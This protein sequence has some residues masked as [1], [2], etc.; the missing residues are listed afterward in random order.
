M[1]CFRQHCLEQRLSRK[2]PDGF[3]EKKVSPL[4]SIFHG[5]RCDRNSLAPGKAGGSFGRL[6]PGVKPYRV[7]RPCDFSDNGFLFF[8]AIPNNNRQT[9]RCAK[10]LDLSMTNSRLT[11]FLV[12]D[13]GHCLK[14][15]RD[16]TCRQLFGPYFKQEFS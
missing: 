11:Q 10:C 2:S 9:S 4:W 13:A 15:R 3:F 8:F 12:Q 7:R 6:P 1:D 5:K 16:N 14:G